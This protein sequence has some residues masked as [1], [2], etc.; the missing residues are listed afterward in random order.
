M[1]RFP[2]LTAAMALAALAL[3]GCQNYGLP[4]GQQ[5]SAVSG[6]ITD[7]ATN[8]PLAGATVV[9]DSVLNAVTDAAGKFSVAR[10]PS[11][12]LDYS[13]QAP[14]YAAL[15]A[16]ANAHPGKPLTLNL[17]LDPASSPAVT[18]SPTP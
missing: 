11:G 16:S 6:T 9:I 1:M 17:S 3:A 4:P 2:R 12:I 10:A 13:V 14:G 5:F 8:Q 7:S 15:S 18:P